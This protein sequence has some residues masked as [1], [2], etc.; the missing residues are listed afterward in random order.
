MMTTSFYNEKFR[1]Q[2]H[3]TPE[4]HWMNDPNGMVFFEGEY[5]LFY[6]YY[7]NGTVWGPMHWGH[8]VSRDLVH[9]EHLPVALAP[10]E[11]G[12]IFSGSAVVDWKDS[13]GLFGGKPGLVAIFTHHRFDEEAQVVRQSQSIAYSADRGRTWLTYEG[14]PV[15]KGEGIVDFRDPKVFWHEPSQ[16]WIMVLAV[17]DHARFYRSADLLNW[18]FC[19]E[20]GREEGSHDGVW[21]CPDLFELPVE[22]SAGDKRWVLIISIGNEEG[23]PEGSRTQYFVGRFDGET[24][25]NEESADQV[26]WLDH[27]RDNY[28]GVTWSDIPEED[29]R[30]LFIGWMSNWKY[31]N[32]TPTESWRGA[33]TLPR[34]LWLK[35]ET[36]GI[37]LYQKPVEELNSLRVRTVTLQE[38][39]VAAETQLLL[40]SGNG[41][42]EVEGTVNVNESGAA[43][44]G[45]RLDYASGQSGT[46]GFDLKRST[47]F[48]DR[49][50]LE[51]DVPFHETFAGRHEASVQGDHET[52]TFRIYVDRSSVE[53]FANGGQAALTDLIFPE[54]EEFELSFYSAG[55]SVEI[56]ELNIH[57]LASVYE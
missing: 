24:F 46:V 56:V 12:Y 10:D 4:A 28:A 42:L 55:G 5:H 50:G 2:F 26:L 20:F 39:L 30:R 41:L 40:E 18:T 47:V 9:W 44:F 6:Q 53:I 17:G 45:F 32:L 23:V 14:N 19:S 7:P 8:A 31:A 29:G 11:H 1:P 3:F 57:E 37:R 54:S 25:V 34:E 22:G 16:H 51:G 13:S 43:E 15:L 49:S 38:R 33:M 27:G 35:K 36:G 21:E 48:I 52:V